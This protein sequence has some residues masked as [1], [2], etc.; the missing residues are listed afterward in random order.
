MLLL[1]GILSLA[2][3]LRL[4]RLDL[5]WF[6]G[7]T[8]RD[9][10]I[11]TEVAT[12]QHWPLLGPVLSQSQAY[13]GPAY[14]YLL[15][16]PYVVV[17]HPLAGAYFIALCNVG[18]IYVLFHFAQT[19]FGRAVAVGASA[20]FAVFPLALWSARTIWNPGFL[21]LFTLLFMR[22]LYALIVH[23]HSRALVALL[24]LLAILMQLHFSAVSLLIV[25][26]LALVLF[27]P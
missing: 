9:L 1:A 10:T 25:V 19:F 7:D 16:V 24:P 27:R 17:K 12:G 21:P 4:Y 23:E 22:A 18:A 3:F 14:F 6:Y 13:L 26:L 2:T 20:L 5:S 15:A 11:A 8:A